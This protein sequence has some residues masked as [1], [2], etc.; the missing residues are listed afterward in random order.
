MCRGFFF[1]TIYFHIAEIQLFTVQF[2]TE[3]NLISYLFSLLQIPMW[4]PQV[5]LKPEPRS[6]RNLIWFNE[7]KLDNV[8]RFF[9]FMIFHESSSP[10]AL[11]ITLRWF[12]ILSNIL[13]DIR[14]ARCTADIVDIGGR[15]FPKI[16]IDDNF[17]ATCINDTDTGINR[18]YPESTYVSVFGEYTER[19]KLIWR[20]QKLS[21]N[22]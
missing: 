1:C 17:F 18:E 9:I 6:I 16:C 13:G 22:K 19:I 14:K 7:L 10:R 8:R 4:L 21:T 20:T 15:I 2:C 3:P 11:I 5:A 12:Q